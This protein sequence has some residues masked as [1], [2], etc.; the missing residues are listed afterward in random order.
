MPAKETNTLPPEA[1]GWLTKYDTAE[2]D[3]DSVARVDNQIDRLLLAAIKDRNK[4][5]ELSISLTDSTTWATGLNISAGIQSVSISGAEHIL[6]ITKLKNFWVPKD[7]VVPPGN[8]SLVSQIVSAAPWVNSWYGLLKV[9]LGALREHVDL[10]ISSQLASRIN[11]LFI[12]FK[13]DYPLDEDPQPSLSSLDG[14]IMFMGNL[15]RPKFPKLVM[16]PRGNIRAIWKKEKAEHIALE[17]LPNDDIRWVVFRND[18][19]DTRRKI[20]VGGIV[21]SYR[22]LEVV[23]PYDIA[24]FISEH[25]Q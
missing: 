23:R 5:E 16:T 22:L 20:R 12:M 19:K 7:L 17:F 8:W 24:N 3:P 2:V 9:R 6:D 13:E 21:P 18:S 11:E 4:G 10:S 14:F 25:Y 1:L 15:I